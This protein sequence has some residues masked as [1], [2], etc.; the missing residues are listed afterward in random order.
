MYERLKAARKALR[1]TQEF[2]AKHMEMSRTTIVAIEAGKREVTAA[3]LAKFSELYGVP[4]DKLVHGEDTNEGKTAMFART[5]SELSDAD[6]A[7]IMNLMRFKKRYRESI[8]A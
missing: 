8:N 7:E 3:E 5:F 2:V 6:Q 1:L 4:M